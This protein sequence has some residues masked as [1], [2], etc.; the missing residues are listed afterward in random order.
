MLNGTKRSLVSLTSVGGQVVKEKT[1]LPAALA[2]HAA[3][4]AKGAACGKVRRYTLRDY[5]R[6]SKTALAKT[7]GV[8]C[9]SP[10][11]GVRQYL[12]RRHRSVRRPAPN[13]ARRGEPPSANSISDF[14]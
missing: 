9:V 13:G 1:G 14:L 5:G 8:F 12:H 2:Q 3:P 7:L 10:D 4:Q 11:A 6:Y